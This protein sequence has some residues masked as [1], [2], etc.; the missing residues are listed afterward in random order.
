MVKIY[1]RLW[2]TPILTVNVLLWDFVYKFISNLFNSIIRVDNAW[3]CMYSYVLLMM[4]GGTAWN[5]W[6][7]CKNK[8]IQE[9]L[10]LVDCNL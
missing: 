2:S 7:V 6:S 5:M 3:S 1:V 10:R 9:K 4:G 8:W